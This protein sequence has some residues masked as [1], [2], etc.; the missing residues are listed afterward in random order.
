MALWMTKL[1]TLL[2]ILFCT[3]L[4]ALIPF[5]LVKPVLERGA[6]HGRTSSWRGSLTELLNCFSGGV[7]LAT[8]LLHLFPELQ[9]GFDEIYT[10]YH[11][12]ISFPMAELTISVGFFFIIIIEHCI[13]CLLK[14]GTNNSV[15]E[16]GNMCQHGIGETVIG[17]NTYSYGIISNT[18]SAS[19]VL[20]SG[21]EHISDSLK[22]SQVPKPIHC[23]NHASHTMS[24]TLGPSSASETQPLLT[25]PQAT[26]SCD[27]P[28]IHSVRSFVL[29]L[30][31]S[32]HTIFEGL[33]LGLLKDA[34]SVWNLFA[35]VLIH[36]VVVAFSLGTQFAEN[37]THRKRSMLFMVIFSFVSPIGIAIGIA[38]SE[39]D[40]GGIGTT[41][42]STILQGLATGTFLHVTFF[43]ILAKEIGSHSTFLKILAVLVGYACIAIVTLFSD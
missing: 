10:F 17:N 7:F 38:I 12:T 40:T 21:R 24:Q 39:G 26:D 32:V 1:V 43:E 8:T 14:R 28:Q 4:F 42:A 20:A 41:L 5:K 3:L 16:R 36:K 33:A 31:L 37:V 23:H 2:S 11:K 30:A 22:C 29:L 6:V 15:S 35:A 27:I 13:I 9:E 25:R 34:S 18:S 19:E